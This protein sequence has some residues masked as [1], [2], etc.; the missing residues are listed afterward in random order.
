MTQHAPDRA[1]SP[2]VEAPMDVAPDPEASLL[3]LCQEGGVE[4]IAFLKEFAIPAVN[5]LPEQY[6]DIQRMP[7]SLSDEWYKSCD[8]E[9]EALRKHNVFEIVACPK[10]WRTISSRWV[11]I[12]KSDGRKKARLVAKGFSQFEGVDFDEIFSPVVRYE[13]IR[14]LLALS[15][16]ESWNIEAL[17]VVSA[18][19]YGK[20]DEE[21]Y[22]EIPEG[23]QA[24]GDKVIRL[25][26]A[27]YGL[28]Q[29]ARAWW[30]QL[31]TSMKNLGFQ[32]CYSDSGVFVHRAKN[33]DIVIAVIYIDDSMMTGNNTSL[34][35]EMKAKIMAI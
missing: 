8:I 24:Q 23:I 9:I 25:N 17:D 32:R 20:L 3:R 5:E 26:R 2:T 19:L 7:K 18:F 4:L 29:A 28:K 12:I 33:N 1:R 11:F 34:T 16:L 10:N 31:A 27:I 13:T 22:M 30:K 15:A 14:T 21:I 35:R 6:R